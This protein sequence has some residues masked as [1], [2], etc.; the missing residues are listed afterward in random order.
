MA[1]ASL[2]AQTF[3]D[4]E[5]VCVDDGSSDD[6]WALLSAQATRDPRF[7]A[8]RFES[9]RGRGAA[10]QFLL[11]RSRGEFLAFLDADDWMF[12]DRLERQL[13]RLDGDP[14]LAA[15]GAP[16]VIFDEGDVAIGVAPATVRGPAGQSTGTFAE[17]HPPT[18]NF[19]A[20]MMRIHFAREAGFDPA[21]FRGQD[22]DLLI[23]ALLGRRYSVLDQP[24]YAYRRAAMTLPKT[25]EGY[26]FRMKA[27]LRHVAQFPFV[28]GRTVSATAAKMTLYK[29]AGLVGLEDR[30][31]ERR[32]QPISDEERRRFEEALDAVR[33]VRVEQW[34]R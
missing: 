26:R 32:Y 7:V 34:P 2:T 1:V 12:P 29:L 3:A 19:P 15:V 31:F 27:H 25:L 6:T 13:A 16:M 4:W 33:R 9:N 22:S 8:H 18:L 21:F 10:R 14:Q 11:E 23:R 17:P 5:C 28:V 20:S 24:A 30:L